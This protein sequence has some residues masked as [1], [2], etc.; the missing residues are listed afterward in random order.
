MRDPAKLP[1]YEYHVVTELAAS[2]F[3]LN[4]FNVS[5]LPLSSYI[6]TYVHNLLGKPHQAIP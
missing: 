2:D 6:H 1:L 4:E 5:F 3:Q